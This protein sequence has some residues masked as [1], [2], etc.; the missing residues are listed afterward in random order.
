M[1][2]E[3]LKNIQIVHAFFDAMGR[4]SR[5]ELR[6][7]Y[8]SFLHPMCRY[9]NTGLKVFENLAETLE[10]FFSDMDQAGGIQ[11]IVVDVHHI[12]AHGSVVFTERTDHH[13]DQTG[14]DL[15]TPL[16]CGIFELRDNL[17][18]AWRDYFDPMPMLE[19][20]GSQAIGTPPFPTTDQ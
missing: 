1:E 5:A 13:Y 19:L 20:F 17:V 15:L 9:Q 7:A 14:N 10:F 12:A 8:E 11:S 16:I 6:D 3:E 4:G 18:Y 2:D